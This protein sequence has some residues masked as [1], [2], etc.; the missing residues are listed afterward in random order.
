MASYPEPV[1]IIKARL[2]RKAF[3]VEEHPYGFMN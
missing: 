3:N 1:P 2:S